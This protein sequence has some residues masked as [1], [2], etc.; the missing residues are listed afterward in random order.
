MTDTEVENINDCK[1]QT[2]S[3]KQDDLININVK[4]YYLLNLYTKELSYMNVY[5]ESIVHDYNLT[6]NN[7]IELKEIIILTNNL[8]LTYITNS[9][10]SHIDNY[11]KAYDFFM[12]SSLTVFWI[13]YK[14]IINDSHITLNILESYSYYASSEILKKEI[15]ILKS[16][17]YNLYPILMNPANQNKDA[18]DKTDQ[19]KSSK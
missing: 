16:V 10:N 3:K 17:D 18:G 13:V 14:F 1:S 19:S 12:L 8:L 9:D 11:P 7:N 2:Q 4:N 15:D 6:S 5:I